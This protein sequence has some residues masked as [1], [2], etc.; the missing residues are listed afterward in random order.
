MLSSTSILKSQLHSPTGSSIH[1]FFEF[2]EVAAIPPK[3]LFGSFWLC[4]ITKVEPKI[5]VLYY[6]KKKN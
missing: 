2:H 1:S 5:K 6:F 4:I 3:K